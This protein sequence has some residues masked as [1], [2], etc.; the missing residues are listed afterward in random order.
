MQI[1]DLGEPEPVEPEPVEPEPVAVFDPEP[2]PVPPEG[3]VRVAV[4]TTIIVEEPVAVPDA[5]PAPEALVE[6]E[7]E[8]APQLEVADDL[9]ELLKPRGGLLGRAFEA[10]G[11]QRSALTIPD[12][13]A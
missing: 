6:P 7:A 1:E 13:D 4:A 5:D 3:S 9:T 2:P 12:D 11:P 8:S 10:T